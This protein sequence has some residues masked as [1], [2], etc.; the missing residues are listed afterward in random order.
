MWSWYAHQ[1]CR[2]KSKLRPKGAASWSA[3][4]CVLDYHWRWLLK[5]KK[6]TT[7]EQFLTCKPVTDKISPRHSEACLKNPGLSPLYNSWQQSCLIGTRQVFTQG[8]VTLS[9]PQTTQHLFF[10]FVIS[11]QVEYSSVPLQL[12]GMWTTFLVDAGETGK[13]PT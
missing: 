7:S 10:S 3:D 6:K 2:I 13:K 8:R 4:V 11:T 12:L 9:K 5:K 1:F